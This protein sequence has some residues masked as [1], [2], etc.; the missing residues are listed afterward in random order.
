MLWLRQTA[1]SN[2]FPHPYLTYM[3]S[4]WEHLFAVHRHTVAAL[5]MYKPRGALPRRHLCTLRV[6]IPYYFVPYIMPLCHSAIPSFHHSAILPFRHSAIPPFYHSAIPPFSH[7]I[8]PPFHH[9]AILPFCHSAIPPFRHFAPVHNNNAT[10]VS[11]EVLRK[12]VRLPGGLRSNRY[13]PTP[14]AK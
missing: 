5:H 2:C 8:L 9:S 3:K 4:V 14:Q 1:T 11:Q 6:L 13:V 10:Y 12:A 7:F